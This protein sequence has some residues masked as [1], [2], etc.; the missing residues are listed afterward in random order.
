M[1]KTKKIIGQSIY[2]ILLVIFY[3]VWTLDRTLHIILPHRQ[4]ENFKV[5]VK[6]HTAVGNSFLRLLFFAF[7]FG[8]YNVV[9][10]ILG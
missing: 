8:L 2:I 9:K 6:N 1:E 7:I 4:H 5:W 10:L 3:I